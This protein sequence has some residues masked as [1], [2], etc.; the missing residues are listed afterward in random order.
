MD[1]RVCAHCGQP[2]N[3]RNGE[4][5]GAWERRAYCSSQCVGRAHGAAVRA[6]Q[7]SERVLDS[8]PCARCGATIQRLATDRNNPWRLKQFC[9]KR[10]AGTAEWEARRGGEYNTDARARICDCGNPAARIL[11]IVQGSAEGKLLPVRLH[12]CTECADMWA[13]DGA[14]EQAPTIPPAARMWG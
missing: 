14:T 11:W 13:E 2:L 5:L 6:K 9:S 3:R 8:K 1:T 12:V 7:A 4:A 10:C